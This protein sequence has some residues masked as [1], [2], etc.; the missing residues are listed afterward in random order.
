MSCV[1][2]KARCVLLCF[3][4]RWT[5]MKCQPW[6]VQEQPISQCLPGCLSLW[7][8]SRR[9]YPNKTVWLRMDAFYLCVRS[10]WGNQGV[11]FLSA[12]LSDTQLWLCACGS[13]ELLHVI[14]GSRSGRDFKVERSRVDHFSTSPSPPSLEAAT[15][16]TSN[17]LCNVCFKGGRSLMLLCLGHVAPLINIQNRSPCF[18][19]FLSCFLPMFSMVIHNL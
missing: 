9:G 5:K 11:L 10:S 15:V 8:F 17:Y 16:F 14:V 19:C 12:L 1:F 6:L 7:P 4:N 3:S 2:K 13:R 18:S